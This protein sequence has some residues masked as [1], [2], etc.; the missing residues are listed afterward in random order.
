M[1]FQLIVRKVKSGEESISKSSGRM[2]TF[3]EQLRDTAALK[4]C[5]A[6]AAAVLEYLSQ[7]K[8]GSVEDHNAAVK[9]KARIEHRLGE[10][11][12]ETV[13]PGNPQF[14]HGVR[15]GKIP[16]GVPPRQSSRTQQL[17]RVPWKAIER[18]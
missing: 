13:R 17:A 2:I 16:D 4:E 11:L 8:D 1:D 10:V 15:N 3:I 18:G 6:Q 12:A 5:K 9:I 14:G 7:R